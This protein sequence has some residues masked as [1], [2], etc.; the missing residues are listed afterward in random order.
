MQAMEQ[1]MNEVLTTR[2][3]WIA[4]LVAVDYVC[5]LLAVLADL[6]SGVLK[7]RR[8][9]VRRT[10]RGFRRSVEKAGRYYVML[11][12]MTLIDAM[13]CGALLF[14]AAADGPSLPP[15]PVF[16]TMGAIGLAMIELKSIYENAQ[17]KS[18]YDRAI[19]QLRKL[20]DDPVIK[21]R[22]L[23]AL[24]LGKPK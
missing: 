16:S 1:M 2:M 17:D 19:G 24:G 23:E 21:G 18:E 10:S 6:R 20:L 12:A 7:A 11:F 13:V 15:L 14:V 4:A 9:G 22:F 5:V 8:Q 3:G